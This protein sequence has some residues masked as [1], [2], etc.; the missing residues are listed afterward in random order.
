MCTTHPH[1][2]IFANEYIHLFML[3]HTHTYTFTLEINHTGQANQHICDNRLKK[4][5]NSFY[6]LI[7]PIDLPLHCQRYIFIGGATLEKCRL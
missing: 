4:K 7:H 2:N 3:T 5:I 1:T 6:T